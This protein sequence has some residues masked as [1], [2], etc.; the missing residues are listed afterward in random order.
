LKAVGN[1]FHALEREVVPET[2]RLRR[3]TLGRP[4]RGEEPT[5]RTVYWL[6]I[7]TGARKR[8]HTRGAETA[9]RLC[10]PHDRAAG[11][12]SGS[13]ATHEV[14]VPGVD[15][16]PFCVHVCLHEGSGLALHLDALIARI[17]AQRPKVQSPIRSASAQT[18]PANAALCVRVCWQSGGRSTTMRRKV[19]RRPRAGGNREICAWKQTAAGPGPLCRRVHALSSPGSGGLC[20]LSRLQCVCAEATGRPNGAR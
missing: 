14:Q 18:P 7:Q 2:V 3:P 8:D 17:G 13:R 15:R 6:R 5:Y 11:A 1:A 12:G 4:R 10:T 9:K 19:R 20:G 16:A